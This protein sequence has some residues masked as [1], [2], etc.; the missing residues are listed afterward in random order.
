MTDIYMRTVYEDQGESIS[1]GTQDSIKEWEQEQ[2][3]WIKQGFSCE[4][5][6]IKKI[7]NTNNIINVLKII[8]Q[9]FKEI[10]RRN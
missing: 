1:F 9:S 7:G 6:S 10:L 4:N 2:N 5:D 3:N 8:N